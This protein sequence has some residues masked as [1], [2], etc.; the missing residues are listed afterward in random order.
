MSNI[1]INSDHTVKSFTL[2]L[3]KTNHEHF[4]Q[5]SN[6]TNIVY[7]G[8]LNSAN[9][10]SFTVYKEINGIKEPLWNEIRDLRLVYVKE[11]DEYFQI[12][13]PM[14]ESSDT[15]KSVTGASQCEAELGQTLISLEINSEDDISRSDYDPNFPT[16]FYRD[17]TNLSRYN[18][19]WNANISKY[20]VFTE[21]KTVDTAKTNTLRTN[22]LKILLLCIEC[23]IRIPIIPSVISMKA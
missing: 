7:K 16:V 20:T 17:I 21:N 22:L 6:A 1:Q 19:I 23:S 14:S 10:L 12:K 4:G 11:M 13:V 15:S 8:N 3:A 2:V 5:I 9:E 18:D